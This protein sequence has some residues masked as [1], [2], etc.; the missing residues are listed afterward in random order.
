M[1]VL[2]EMDDFVQQLHWL[3][4]EGA[5]FVPVRAHSKQ[6]CHSDW[7]NQPH[8]LAQ[9]EAHVRV[10]GNVGLLVGAPSNG[11]CVLDLDADF[12]KF[13][14]K[15]PEFNKV[16]RI[17]RLGGGD[18]GK[19]IIRITD[20]VP[21]PRKWRHPITNALA[22]EWL[23]T[24]NHAV[25]PP[26]IHPT[27]EAFF[28]SNPDH[29]IPEFTTAKMEYIWRKWTGTPLIYK[30]EPHVKGRT[31]RVPAP[32][33]GLVPAKA[34]TVPASTPAPATDPKA[35]IRRRFDMVRYACETLNTTAVRESAT[36]YRILGQGGL[37]INVQQ[38]I[39][40]TFATDG[41]GKTGGDC[42][43]LIAYLT[44]GQVRP[45]GHQWKEVF[46]IAAEYVGIRVENGERREERTADDREEKGENPGAVA[47]LSPLRSPLSLYL[48]EVWNLQGSARLVWEGW[49]EA[50][51]ITLIGGVP[52]V[53]KSPLLLSIVAGYLRGEWPDG[54]P[55]P[56]FFAG[57][58][59]VYYLPEGFASQTRFLR[60]WGLD[61][62]TVNRVHVPFLPGVGSDP[63][64]DFAFS[65]DEIG[66][67]R[68]Q[69]VCEQAK[70][71]LIVIDGLRAAMV[72]EESSSTDVKTFYEPLIQLA[73]QY[74]AV[75][76]IT[77]HLTKGAETRSRTGELPSMDWFRGSGDL[78][79]PCRSAWIV[80]RPNPADLHT[81]RITLVKAAEGP[82]QV[83]KAFHMV[84]PADGITFGATIP[85]PP[86]ATKKE[87]A[88]RF[89]LDML[90]MDGPLTHE[91]VV[92]A[93]S[94][95]GLDFSA[96]TLRQAR[97][98]LS[99]ENK[100]VAVPEGRHV[101]KWRIA[102]HD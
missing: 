55:V 15:F 100:I 70:P 10:G 71:A 69:A 63:K 26:S 29:P 32:L 35:H 42:F 58:D 94:E 13:L 56:D 73:H 102:S 93:A 74:D 60:D 7:Q 49:M 23:S 2:I 96:E 43:D 61:E 45:T 1:R 20:G 83:T 80:D 95:A 82:Q 22:A 12:T 62:A 53:G 57:R 8:T 50:G 46:R 89:Y 101:R 25:L 86:A 41:S 65:L 33:A 3:E 28:W 6:P 14:L 67:P 11:L 47:V 77:H 37:L 68:L 4:T 92:Q 24:G 64:P 40:N 31:F 51:L 21:P 5:T 66:L 36:E 84:A 17:M 27:G 44:V 72:G 78:L 87:E 38:Q 19:F 76:L 30:P 18:R 91:E 9:V 88:S 16:P 48:S 98:D 85:L 75:V 90:V 34:N 52:N 81:R 54:T 59:V 99:R 97:L 79:R 39:W